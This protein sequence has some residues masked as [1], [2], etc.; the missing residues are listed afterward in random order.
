MLY[1]SPHALLQPAPLATHHAR[2]RL[3]RTGGRKTLLRN[4][5]TRFANTSSREDL[6]DIVDAALAKHDLRII[7]AMIATVGI[8]TAIIIAANRFF[9]G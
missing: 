4:S 1:D 2:R 6:R 7:Q 9:G 3:L 5:T 8:A